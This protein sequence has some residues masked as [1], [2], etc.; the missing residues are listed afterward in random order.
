MT[1]RITISLLLLMSITV[2]SVVAIED[3]S[4]VRDDKRTILTSPSAPISLDISFSDA[5]TLNQA[6][7]VTCTMTSVID[8]LN[9]TA[10]IVLPEG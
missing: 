4:V 2:G 1:I 8:A 3:S 10:K 6:A 5:P 7:E 9:T